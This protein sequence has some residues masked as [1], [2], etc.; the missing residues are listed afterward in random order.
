M[1]V[2]RVP[3]PEIINPRD[4]L[5]RITSTAIC[6]SDLHLYGGKVPSMMKGDILGHEFM[7]VVEEVGKGVTNLKK[8]DRVAVPFDIACGNCYY[9]Q[10]DLWSLCDNSNPNAAALEEMNGFSTAGLFGYSHLYGGYAGGQA[11]YVRVPFADVGPLKIESGI[12]DEKVLFLT[13][14]F[15]TGYQ[16]A[17]QCGIR[18]GDVV[19]VWGAGPVGQFAV[20]SAFMLGA[21]RV[22]VIDRFADRL[23]KAR[24]LWGAE[25][26]NYESDTDDVVET[27]KQLT[28]GRG[29]DHVIDA[30]G[31]E[32][33]GIGMYANVE[34]AK[35]FTKLQPDRATV[36]RQCIQAC[37]KGGTVSLPGVYTGFVDKFPMGQA[38]AKGLT[39]KMGQTHTHKYMRPLLEKVERGEI[40]PSRIITHTV[41]LDDAPK[42]YEIFQ[43]KRD[44]CLKVVLKP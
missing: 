31:M 36:L 33:H 26:L 42:M 19:A 40:D 22:I 4:A 41:R 29:P 44:D 12:E 8:G 1:R 23:A 17:E 13:D 2:D 21:E 7:G 20:A 43:E 3:D 39:F 24:D 6:G 10:H 16:A 18:R 37:G 28:G 34:R 5:V 11:E 14:I 15:P 35:Q 25:V 38:F 9:C 32:A 27:L 30:V